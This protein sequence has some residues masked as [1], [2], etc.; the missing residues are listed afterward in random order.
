MG[1]LCEALASAAG[2]AGALIRTGTPVASVLVTDDRAV[3]VSLES[4]EQ[5]RARSVISSVDPKTTFLRLVGPRHLDTGFVRRV[6]HIRARGLAAKLHLALKG[7]PVFTGVSAQQ[8]T[9]RLLQAPSLEFVEHAYNHAK[10]GEFS[11]M[12]IMEITVPTINDPSLAPAGHHVLSAIV[13]YVPYALKEGWDSGRARLLETALDTLERLAPGLRDSVLH[14]ELLT[15]PDLEREFR[16]SGGHWHQ[17][18]LAFDQFLMVRPVPGAA[19]YRTPLPGLY[20]CGAGCHPGGGVMGVA[21]RNAAQQVLQG[22]R[23][24]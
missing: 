18:D 19:Q 13:Q 10:Y 2:A 1:A 9:G 5:I 24:A 17:G 14:A 20:L 11:S 4:G 23:A 15:P 16:S 12:P 21:G 22:A 3:G 7:A 8:L 6:A